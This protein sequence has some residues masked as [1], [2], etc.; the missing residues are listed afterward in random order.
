MHVLPDPVEGD[1]CCAPRTPPPANARRSTGCGGSASTSTV[2]GRA[3]RWFAEPLRDAQD[4]AVP[5]SYN[6]LLADPRSRDHVGEV[7]YQRTVRV[8]RG[9]AGQRVVLYFES[10]THR[11]TV[12]VGDEEV[13]RHEGGYTPFEADVTAVAQPGELVRITVCV[14]NTLSFQTIPPGV[15]EQTATGPQPAVLARLLQLR[16]P[17][18]HGLARLHA[19]GPDRGRHRRH[20]PRRHHRHGRLPGGSRRRGRARRARRAARRRRCVEVGTSDR[21]AQ[22]W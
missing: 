4:M 3:E 9:W 15:V 19:R 5:A 2:S 6:D 21:C 10:A 16:G 11:A 22:A 18:P 17:A 8:P 12:W 20:R 13:V 7:W 1:P 14:D